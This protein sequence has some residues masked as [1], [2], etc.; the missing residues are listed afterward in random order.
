MLSTA[1]QIRLHHCPDT[2]A[3]TTQKQLIYL[4]LTEQLP[5]QLI[6]LPQVRSGFIGYEFDGAGGTTLLLVP[7]KSTN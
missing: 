1:M 5:L 4:E 7:N 2:L 6:R 3:E